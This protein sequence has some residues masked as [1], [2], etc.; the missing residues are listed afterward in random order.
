MALSGL[1]LGREDSK[2]FHKVLFHQF[3]DFIY[4]T[5]KKTMYMH[6]LVHYCTTFLNASSDVSGFYRGT[7]QGPQTI[8]QLQSSLQG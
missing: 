2:V 3:I 4:L 7:T 1:F 5:N 6:V 8:L